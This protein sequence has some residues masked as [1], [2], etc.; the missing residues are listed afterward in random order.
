MNW[1]WVAFEVMIN[2]VESAFTVYLANGLFR[3]SKGYP[4]SRWIMAGMIAVGTAWATLYLFFDIDV[5]PDVL[6]CIAILFFY[7]VFFL[8]ASW[9]SALLW[10]LIN[11]VILGVLAYAIPTAL[12]MLLHQPFQM[13]YEQEDVRI[14]FTILCHIIWIVLITCIVKFADRRQPFL[15]MRKGRML[16]LF[17]PLFSMFL[18]FLLMQY[19]AATHTTSIS[20]FL[21]IATGIGLLIINIGS[22]YIFNKMTHQA[23]EVVI[24]QTHRKMEQQQLHHQEELQEVY[25]NMR[26][27]RH[28]FN[29]HIHVLQ[30]M[31][32]M[33]KY[34]ELQ[35]Y[36]ERVSKQLATLNEF[37]NTGNVAVDALLSV[38]LNMAKSHNITMSID[39]ALTE[40]SMMANE[41]FCVLL[42]NLFSNAY[43]ACLHI[44]V[45][46]KRFIKLKLH[47]KKEN[48]YLFMENSTDGSEKRSG[49]RW[50]TTKEE[51]QGHGLGLISIDNII[52]FYGGF[53]QRRH[54]QQVFTTSIMLPLTKLTRD[55]RPF[56]HM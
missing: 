37:V 28:D 30:G 17:T 35:L 10:A 43:E 21:P 27:F 23:E 16:F 45:A 15:F 11:E 33:K 50:L 25:Q 19:G 22:L 40:W 49:T 52:E 1:F 41:H 55:N 12:S 31:L 46:E 20:N 7:S 34:E 29:N 5:I 8:K 47:I 36:L 54:E 13:F 24:L 4:P 56:T 51:M 39:A 6:P 14:L 18:I 42:G 2:F 48:F 9:Y 3:K 53:C 38:Q 44:P 32:Q 26:E